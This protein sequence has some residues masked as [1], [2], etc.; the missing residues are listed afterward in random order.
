MSFCAN[1][2]VVASLELGPG[3][4]P[5]FYVA[6]SSKTTGDTL[7]NNMGFWLFPTISKTNF[8]DYDDKDYDLLNSPIL[9]GSYVSIAASPTADQSPALKILM[10]RTVEFGVIM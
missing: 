6:S 8:E 2:N 5:Y 10:G 9:N 1:G 4:L 3:K 7:I